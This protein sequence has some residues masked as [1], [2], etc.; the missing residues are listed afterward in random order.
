MTM[1]CLKLLSALGLGFAVLSAPGFA[2]AGQERPNARD[3]ALMLASVQKPPRDDALSA[4]GDDS[5]RHANDGECDQPGVGTGACE[6]GT[7][8]SDCWR[9]MTGREDDSCQ[10]ANDGE[11][12]EPSFGTGACT[13]GT[14]LSDCGDVS[15]LRFRDDSCETAF[16]GVCE[17]PGLGSGTCDAR[18]DR[19]DCVGRARPLTINDHFFGEDDRQLF[20][21]S[22]FPWSVI[23]EIDLEIGGA[24]TAA[25][26]GP[27]ILISAAHC[28]SD[29]GR[30]NAA[31]RFRT[32]A[33]RE[34]GVVTANVI[35]FLMDAAWD[36][37]LFDETD[38]VDHADWV[39]LRLDAPIGDTLGYLG[40]A[41]LDSGRR[42]AGRVD[43]AAAARRS[44][45]QSPDDT[46]AQN[47][48]AP[49]VQ[50]RLGAVLLLF[51]GGVI[52]LGVALAMRA[53]GLRV[54]IGAVAAAAI[55][56]AVAAYLSPD[57]LV[58][59]AMDSERPNDGRDSNTRA[60]PGAD[61]P[62]PESGTE[63]SPP[64]LWQAGYSWDT[65]ENLSGNADC[66][67]LETYRDDT[68]S[69]DC[70]TT[71]G[72]SGSPFLVREAGAWYVVATDSNFRSNPD[73]PF[74][75]ISVRS[76]A[77]IDQL[78]D[79]AAGRIGNGGARPRGPGK[80][81]PLEPVKQRAR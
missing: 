45:A 53:L 49:D 38:E 28:V 23:G 9:I 13:Q 46:V 62:E 16:N 40:V 22:V 55:A 74:V 2:Q 31:G 24:C 71:R 33:A 15:A 30:V 35:D 1:I 19:S 75:Y 69:H 7:D 21:T 5:C 20:D 66:R 34:G 27:D 70:D 67:V 48:P 65:G 77:W 60:E 39:L 50:V 68:F 43:D 47:A 6:A 64:R 73:G 58:R 76:E 12:D 11:C 72:D 14:D 41:S 17:E 57:R 26:I 81:E 80:P 63:A 51:F 59:F 54:L 78:D 37:T 25:L 56:G 18:A 10:W 42:I 61:T 44:G 32:A 4:A 79:F 8:Y 52:L 29:E 36:Q 3:Y